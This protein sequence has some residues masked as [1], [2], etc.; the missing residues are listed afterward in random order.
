M[1]LTNFNKEV[2]YSSRFLV[3]QI[4]IFRKEEGNRAEI[5]HSDLL[6][7]IE[8]EF[9][10]EL[11]EGNISF[12]SY[13]DL[14]NQSRKQYDLTFEYSLQLIMSESKT[15]RK[16][17]VEIMKAQQ[18]QLQTFFNI[19][20]TFSEALLLAGKQQEV[21]EKQALLIEGQVPKVEAFDRVID[22]STVYTLDTVSDI[23]NIG[24][25]KLSSRLKEIGW[26]IK[27][28]SK[29]TSSTRSAEENGFAKTFFE[30]IKQGQHEFKVKKIV[31]T[32]RGLDHL[33]NNYNKI[34]N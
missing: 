1:E 26:A 5:V 8:R 7:K 9:N 3:E 25:T 22:N 13:L 12:G 23:V 14:N 24:R 16:R 20:K 2:K 34:F 32:K 30:T 18:T 21:I 10:E 29:G 4:N 11:A 19:P 31:I 6:K 17:C 33:I 28:S 27:D 15:V